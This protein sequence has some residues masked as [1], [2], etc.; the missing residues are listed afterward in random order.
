MSL[1]PPRS[2]RPAP[3]FPYP[4]LFRSKPWIWGRC[5]S[6]SP[7]WKPSSASDSSVTTSISFVAIS[8]G[9][10][11]SGHQPA[12]AEAVCSSTQRSLSREFI[13]TLHEKGVGLV[14]GEGVETQVVEGRVLQDRKSTRLNSSH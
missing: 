8:S 4:T 5:W 7:L 2:T 6:F 11:S 14:G 9:V 12:L 1:R 13:K 3:L 10:T